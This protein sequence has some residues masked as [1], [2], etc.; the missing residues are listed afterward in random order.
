MSNFGLFVRF[1]LRDGAA[2][3]FDTL[4]RKTTAAI[5]AK[6][7][8]TLVYAC[9]TVEGAPHERI[10]FELYRDH[11]AFEEHERQEH[12]RHFLAERNKYVTK[13]EVDRM[14]PFAG[15][16]PTEANGG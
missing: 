5:E 16:Y 12:T 3:D 8:G 7:P 6:E 9:H 10:F 11:A 13:T 15:K 14:T 2:A 1:T 4:V